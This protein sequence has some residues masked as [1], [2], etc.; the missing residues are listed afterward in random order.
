[1]ILFANDDETILALKKSLQMNENKINSSISSSLRKSV[2]SRKSLQLDIIQ[3]EN[4]SSDYSTSSS[5]SSSSGSSSMSSDSESLDESNDSYEKLDRKLKV[6]NDNF[7]HN[8]YDWC[9]EPKKSC[10]PNRSLSE[11]SPKK[12]VT[13]ADSHGRQLELVRTMSEPSNC[14]PKLNS[15]SAQYFLNK[16]YMC[17]NGKLNSNELYLPINSD[18]SN[19]KTLVLYT[20]NFEQPAGDYLNFQEKINRSNVSLENVILNRFHISGTIKA[21]NIC[22]E[23]NVFVRCT[24]NSWKTYKDIKAEYVPSQFEGTSSNFN[25]TQSDTFKFEFNLPNEINIDDEKLVTQLSEHQK[26]FKNVEFCVCFISADSQQHWDSNYGLNYS[27]LKYALDFTHSYTSSSTTKAATSTT[28][29]TTTTTAAATKSTSTLSSSSTLINNTPF[30]SSTNSIENNYLKST[31]QEQT[32]NTLIDKFFYNW[33]A[34]ST[35]KVAN[36]MLTQSTSSM[37][38]F[39]YSTRFLSDFNS[40]PYW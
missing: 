33:L 18:E 17:T 37:N 3:K 13:F 28:T 40:L 5:A 16:E 32:L 36:T 21:K 4:E 10:M 35:V 23:K 27:I 30:K 11:T 9:L 15:K 19:K 6:L 12:H 8:R 14:P 34:S 29:T 25:T 24:F 26:C 20:L 2:K 31:L 7:G 38:E 39:N 22:F 1:M